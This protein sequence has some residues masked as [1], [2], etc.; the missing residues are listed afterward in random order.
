[1]KWLTYSP[2]FPIDN[3]IKPKVSAFNP[4]DKILEAYTGAI[5]TFG[6]INSMDFNGKNYILKWSRNNSDGTWKCDIN[7]NTRLRPEE[8]KSIQSEISNYW[9]NYN[10]NMLDCKKVLPD[11]VDVNYNGIITLI[12]I[13]DRVKNKMNIPCIVNITGNYNACKNL[14]EDAKYKNLKYKPVNT[15]DFISALISD[16]TINGYNAYLLLLDY[17]IDNNFIV[18]RNKLVKIINSLF[19]NIH[20]DITKEQASSIINKF[21]EYANK[22]KMVFP[23]A[24]L[25]SIYNTL[26]KYFDTSFSVEKKLEYLPGSRF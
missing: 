3:Y 6:F 9:K 18:T 23:H 21:I 2:D 8:A 5:E 11:R 22:Y 25:N 12:I 19:F 20:S 4:D 17:G 24:D 16:F 14:D 7:L 1:M 15:E 13:P 10:Q 26:M